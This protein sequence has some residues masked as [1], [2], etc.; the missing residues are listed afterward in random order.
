MLKTNYI[1]KFKLSLKE[2]LKEIYNLS[3][4]TKLD[5]VS[6]IL[7]QQSVG[8]L[9]R[10]DAIQLQHMS[11]ATESNRRNRIVEIEAT[12]K[13]IEKKEFGYCISCGEEISIKRLEIDSTVLKC[14][15]CA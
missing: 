3:K 12:L 1:D 8:R 7:D 6:V 5:R 4:K 13:R 10:M 14:I 9:S 11:L 2:E 15:D